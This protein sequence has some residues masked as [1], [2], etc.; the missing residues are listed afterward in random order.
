MRKPEPLVPEYSPFGSEFVVEKLKIHKS[1]CTDHI[2]AELTQAGGN[3][4]RYETY[5]LVNSVR[6]KEELTQQ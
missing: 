1:P 5:R 4:L 6:T 2:P 3:T